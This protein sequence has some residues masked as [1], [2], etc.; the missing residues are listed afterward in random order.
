[1]TAGPGTVAVAVAVGTRGSAEGVIPMSTL[2][3]AM[4]VALLAALGIAVLVY[5]I[6][7]HERLRGRA[8][9]RSAA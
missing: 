4:A 9:W 2:V 7:R 8:R 6:R 5:G 3:G 1:M